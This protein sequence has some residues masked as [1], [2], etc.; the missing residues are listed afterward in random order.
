MIE[1]G[2]LDLVGFNVG[3][4]CGDPP[5]LRDCQIFVGGQCVSDC[6]REYLP[7]FRNYFV[8]DIERYRSKLNFLTFENELLRFDNLTEI[9]NA[10]VQG[11]DDSN[12]DV[13]EIERHC[14]F[15]AWYG[16]L[17]TDLFRAFL[18]PFRG[19]L[20]LTWQTWV[21]HDVNFPKL[22]VVDCMQVNPYDLIDNFR[23]CLAKLDDADSAG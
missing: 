9:H 5:S 19:H 6:K 21:D 4:P 11:T 15:L 10:F 23:D 17:T 2:N 18:I 16:P 1:L 3:Q 13:E 12:G 20:W 8:S 7:F 22:D 14:A